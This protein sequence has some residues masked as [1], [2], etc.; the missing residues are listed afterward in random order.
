MALQ[1]FVSYTRQ[2]QQLAS[3]LAAQLRLPAGK[4]VKT[5]IDVDQLPSGLAF[6]P[7]ITQRI[8]ASDWFVLVYTQGEKR[9]EYPMFEAGQYFDSHD[10][11][12]PAEVDASREH[13]K[14]PGR[15]CCLYDTVDIPEVF[16]PYQSYRV[17]SYH[18]DYGEQYSRLHGIQSESDFYDHVPLQHFLSDFYSTPKSNPILPTYMDSSNRDTRILI[19]KTISEAFDA[20]A[21][22]K[23]VNEDV[24]QH[25]LDLHITREQIAGNSNKPLFDEMELLGQ[26]E[27]IRLFGLVAT[28][29]LT[30]KDLRQVF[31]ELG[32]PAPWMDEMEFGIASVVSRRRLPE[33]MDISFTIPSDQEH[34]RTFRPVLA[35]FQEYQRGSFNFYISL[36]ESK[37]RTL[38]NSDLLISG[39]IM[40][41]RF[42]DM[43]DD[44]QIFDDNVKGGALSS[45]A[46]AIRRRLSLI[47]A[48]AFELG[49]TNPAK[50][51]SAMNDEHR[52]E[53]VAFFDQWEPIRGR[54]VSAL[55]DIE[56]KADVKDKKRVGEVYASLRPINKKFLTACAESYRSSL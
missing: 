6:S 30:W 38:T 42:R 48:E 3:K 36:Y 44:V 27:T 46:R 34:G 47:E 25:R 33:P 41:S 49:L 45:A 29:D 8:N 19:A 37:F 51:T 20:N 14:P 11:I 26:K 17:F 56:V 35:R 21:F 31:V 22:D 23:I 54:F 10:L 2:D 53:V 9:Y 55:E 5:F 50:L 16:R 24:L 43:I 7:S 32:R 52:E 40:G 28:T 1:L 12:E 39:I 18:S 13:G 15:F 4:E